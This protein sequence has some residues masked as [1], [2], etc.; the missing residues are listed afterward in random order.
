MFDERGPLDSADLDIV[1]DEFRRLGFAPA[2]FFDSGDAVLSAE[3][4]QRLTRNA[5]L[6]KRYT[7]FRVS[8]VGHTDIRG[9]NEENLAL[10]ERRAEA[11]STFLQEMGVARVRLGIL[12]F[13]EE[14]PVHAAS[15]EPSAE[16]RRVDLSI[17][18]RMNAGGD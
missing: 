18:G 11:V 6:L 15:D 16:D 9:T 7:Q 2:V 14:R 17:T 3:A 8:I 12:S 10:G 5:A 4:Q 1:N 13:G